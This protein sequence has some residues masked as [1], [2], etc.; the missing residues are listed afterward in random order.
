[1]EEVVCPHHCLTCR[2][3]KQ[4]R[5]TKDRDG[6]TVKSWPVMCCASEEDW[7]RMYMDG[8]GPCPYRR[9]YNG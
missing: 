7:R 8:K 6:H 9:S 3:G 4:D 1:M 2:H 5:K